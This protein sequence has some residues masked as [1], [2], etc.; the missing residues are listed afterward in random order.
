MIMKPFAHVPGPAVHAGLGVLEKQLQRGVL[1]KAQRIVLVSD[2]GLVHSGAVGRAMAVLGER[3]ALSSLDVVTDGDCAAAEALV[4]QARSHDIDGIIALGGG[5]VI[6]TAKAVAAM[7]ATDHLMAA[8]D[9]L[10]LVKKKLVRPQL[11]VLAIPT[12]AGTGA[13]AT[14]F[15]VLADRAAHKKRIL[16][17]G[18]LVPT[19][20]ILDGTLCTSMPSSVTRSSAVD[21]VTHAVEALC[22]SAAHP[23]ADAMA[24]ESLR[25][26]I[27]GKALEQTLAKPDD[28]DARQASLVAAHLAGCA[29]SSANLGACHALAH[30]LG[31]LVP[32]PHG[33][34]NGTLLLA[35]LAKNAPAITTP[36]ARISEAL[37]EDAVV[38]LGR[39]IHEVGEV[40]R[41]LGALGFSASMMD[42]LVARA[43]ADPDLLTNPIPLNADDLRAIATSCL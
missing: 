36:L 13:E 18:T 35:V 43:V 21:A 29:I 4:V 15:A 9:G 10:F 40:P 31:T 38:S 42:D 25:I 24:L 1:A 12:T 37:G 19:A 6:D 41:T 11:P 33:V 8:L 17:D 30:A 28:A 16:I 7:L 3:V 27:G 14:Q 22:S 34:C 5:S 23:I 2:A 39:F 32:A 20:A 26:M